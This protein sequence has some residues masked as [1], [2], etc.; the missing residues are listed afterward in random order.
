MPRFDLVAFDVDGTLVLHPEQLTVWEVLN[1]RFTGTREHNRERYALYHGDPLLQS[2][3]ALVPWIITWDDHEVDND[4][5]GDVSENDDDAEAFRARRAAGYQAWYE[6]M[7]VRGYAGIGRNHFNMHRRIV[8][9]DL[10]QISLLDGRQFRDDREICD[11]NDYPDFGFGAYG[12]SS[13]AGGAWFYIG[14]G[15]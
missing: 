3:H 5:A 13:Y 15:M 11:N 12:Y 2:A 1:E 8:L 14:G 7:P 6:H 10:A 4:Y 9:G